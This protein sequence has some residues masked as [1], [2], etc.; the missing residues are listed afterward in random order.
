MTDARAIGTSAERTPHGRLLNY[1]RLLNALFWITSFSGSIVF[2]EPSPYDILVLLTMAV[3]LLGGVRVRR[4]V[5]PG[6]FLLCMWTLGGYL[7]LVPYWNEPDPVDFMTRTLLVATTGVFYMLFFSENTSERFDLW[8]S[9]YAASCMLASAIAIGGW[10]GVFGSEEWLKSERALGPFKDPNVLGTYM[11]PGVLYFAQKL[12]L[13]RFQFLPVTLAGLALSAAALFVSF[14]RGSW[15]AAVVSLLLMIAMSVA[16]S[17]SHKA[18]FR[19]SLVA[20]AV[21]LL[22]VVVVFGILSDDSVRDFFLMRA[23]P[24]QD[25]DEGPTGRFGNQL[26]SLPMLM[27]RPNGMGPLRFR[28]TFGLDPHSS[29][30]NAFASNGWLGG[31]AFIGLAALT[32]FV[33]FRLCFARSPYMRRAQLVW[34]ALLAF[35]L[36]GLQIDI[37]HWRYL[38]I[39]LGAIWGLEAARTKWIAS[40]SRSASSLRDR[41]GAEIEP[42][43]RTLR[44]QSAL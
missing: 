44:R 30:V 11:V 7:S 37:D 3:W 35:F 17:D 43:E 4:E 2:I 15:G 20:L 32:G 25:Y 21:V 9:G 19:T 23:S 33:G 1:R 41:A 34:P 28:L 36:Q 10:M 39:H 26:R 18:R 14:S 6:I 12:L 22:G 5:L 42:A 31:F 29:Y 27:E 16:T 24:T 8:M 13:G 38:F 40:R